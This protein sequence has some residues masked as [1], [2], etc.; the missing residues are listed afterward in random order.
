MVD[1]TAAGARNER[2]NTRDT[3][4]SVPFWFG[5]PTRAYESLSAKPSLPPPPD[6]SIGAAVETMRG[7]L[8]RCALSLERERGGQVDD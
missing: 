6:K 8:L 4:R 5:I 3:A 1:T 2:I 7:L